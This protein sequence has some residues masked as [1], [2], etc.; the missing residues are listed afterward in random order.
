MLRTAGKLWRLP[1]LLIFGKLLRTLRL[2]GTATENTDRLW[3]REASLWT[4]EDEPK[5]LDWMNIVDQQLS[6]VARFK[7]LA[8]EVAEDAFTHILL[9]GMGGSSLCPEVFSKT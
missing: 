6:E 4:N 5:W 2:R 9:L 1:C 7:A 8:A 3:K